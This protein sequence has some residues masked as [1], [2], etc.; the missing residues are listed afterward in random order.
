MY[1]ALLDEFEDD[2]TRTTED[3]E[4][5]SAEPL[6]EVIDDE[7]VGVEREAGPRVPDRHEQPGER[8]RTDEAHVLAQR[9]PF[10]PGLAVPSVDQSNGLGRPWRSASTRKPRART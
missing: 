1:D 9:V 6:N 8:E 5:F 7:A 4:G 3:V 2:A 10:S